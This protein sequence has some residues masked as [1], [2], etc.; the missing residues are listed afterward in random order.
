MHRVVNLTSVAIDVTQSS[1]Y[2]E[3]IRQKLAGYNLNE[4]QV[5]DGVNEDGLPTLA[6]NADFNSATEANDF[7]DWL[8]QYI[9]DRKDQFQSA[10]T[11]VHDCYHASGQNLPCQI[12]DVWELV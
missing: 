9:T 10:R 12:G 3:D 7:H 11:R 4:S 1:L 6:V 8:K 5:N 2:K